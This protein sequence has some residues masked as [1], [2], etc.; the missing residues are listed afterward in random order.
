[1]NLDTKIATPMLSSG[2]NQQKFEIQAIEIK[3][4]LS[5]WLKTFQPL[6][7]NKL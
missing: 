2:K 6:D 7:T 3:A 5:F 4:G 1:M